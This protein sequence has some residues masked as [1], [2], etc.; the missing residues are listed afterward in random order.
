MPLLSD[1]EAADMAA[2]RDAAAWRIAEFH[3]A[4]KLLPREIRDPA[5]AL[6]AFCR[7]A[8]DVIERWRH[9]QPG[10]AARAAGS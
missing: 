9:R 5:I 1:S 7:E 6:Y 8:D 4:S 3:A 10:L 2:C